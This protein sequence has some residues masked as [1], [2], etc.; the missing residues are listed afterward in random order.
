MKLDLATGSRRIPRRWVWFAGGVVA[1]PIAGVT[2]LVWAIPWIGLVL[3][4]ALIALQKR[5]KGSASRNGT[6]A[7]AIAAWLLTMGAAYLLVVIVE[8]P[9]GAD[10]A[11]GPTVSLTIILPLLFALSGAIAAACHEV[12]ERYLQ[13]HGPS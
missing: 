8:A 7:W 1:M 6:R 10:L 11:D 2:A 5:Y 4:A 9:P 3:L 12:A 13:R